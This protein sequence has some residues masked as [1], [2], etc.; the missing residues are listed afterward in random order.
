MFKKIYFNIG[1]SLLFRSFGVLFTLLLNYLIAKYCGSEGYGLFYQGLTIFSILTI[2]GCIGLDNLV[3]FKT[4]E[5]SSI[6]EIDKINQLIFSVYK[7]V[8]PTAII[9]SVLMFLSANFLAEYYYKEPQLAKTIQLFSLGILP[10]ILLQLN[11][12]NLKGSSKIKTASFLQGFAPQ[13][14]SVL[15]GLLFYFL[16]YKNETGFVLSTVVTYWLVFSISFFLVKRQLIVDQLK[17]KLNLITNKELLKSSKTFWITASVSIISSNVV[18]LVLGYY[19][20]SKVIGVYG[21]AVKVSLII[22]F[23]LPSINSA[24]APEFVKNIVKKDFSTLDKLAKKSSLLMSAIS[25]PMVIF[26]TFFSD[27]VMSLFGEE[28]AAGGIILTILAWGQFF[29]AVTG[30]VGYILMSA[31]LEK[32]LLYS[33]LYSLVFSLILSVILIPNYGIVGA[34]IAVASSIAFQNL[35][36]SY[37]CYSKL[38]IVPLFFIKHKL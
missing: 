37:I 20:D 30:S 23:I 9:I 26:L 32:Y 24:M 3:L 21:I 25:I 34:S 35:Y 36:S 11:S 29:K 28:F 8:I 15:L 18:A 19:L 13:F 33:I 5:H 1:G 12:E 14:L 38:S 7:F 4:S 22:S 17:N 10:F 27:F 31:R 6:K 16:F 2:V